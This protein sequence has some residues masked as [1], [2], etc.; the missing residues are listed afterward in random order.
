MRVYNAKEV[1][2]KAFLDVLEAYNMDDIT[3]KMVVIESG[4][5][6]QTLY[7]HYGGLVDILE[8]IY[9]N[10]IF[11]AVIERYSYR[12]W[13]EGFEKMLL[14]FQSRKKAFL[15]I[16]DS[17]YRREF[18]NMIRKHG[19]VLIQD[20]L[21][22][23]SKERNLVLDKKDETFMMNYYLHVF[24]GIIELY[25]QS[26]M[27]EDPSYLTSRLDVMMRDH[28]KNSLDNIKKLYSGEF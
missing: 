11:G 2:R 4:V 19:V 9:K 5:S 17:S 14:Y 26:N 24:L 12:E 1:L 20:G 21:D 15:H 3:V 10:E 18:L 23:L 6:K 28:M 13:V 7:N 8:D 22:A 25:F 27:A 16:Y